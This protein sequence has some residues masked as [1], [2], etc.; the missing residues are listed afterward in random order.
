MHELNSQE[1]GVISL[2]IEQ[3][4]LTYTPLQNELLDHVCC[5]IELMMEQGLTFNEAYRKVK[6]DMGKNKKA[7]P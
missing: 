4:G 6:A 5:Q 3:Q 1:V 2:D 7:H